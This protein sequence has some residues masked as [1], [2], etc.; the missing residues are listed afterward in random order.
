ME[1]CNAIASDTCSHRRHTSSRH[2]SRRM[3]LADRNVVKRSDHRKD[4]VRASQLTEPADPAA[5]VVKRSACLRQAMPSKTDLIEL[6]C[7]CLKQARLAKSRVAATL[8]RMAK[9]YEQRA[10]Q[11]DI[12]A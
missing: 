7:I 11:L 2:G 8:R 12:A 10:A 3:D 1:E 4:S 6:A 5:F 9:D